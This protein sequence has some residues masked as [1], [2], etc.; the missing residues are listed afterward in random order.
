MCCAPSAPHAG[1]LL[2]NSENE[3]DLIFSVSSSLTEERWRFPAHSVILGTSSP[4][5]QTLVNSNKTIMKELAEQNRK[6]EIYVQCPPEIF[7]LVLSYIYTNELTISSVSNC[8]LLLKVAIKFE[9]DNLIYVCLTFLYDKTSPTNLIDIL[10]CLYELIN[11]GN[12]C[13]TGLQ[14]NNST[15]SSNSQS[16]SPSSSSSSNQQQE[17]SSK[18]KSSSNNLQPFGAN[19]NN[20]R[21]S[22]YPER[23]SPIPGGGRISPYFDGSKDSKVMNN[24]TTALSS[25]PSDNIVPQQPG[26]YNGNC[27]A[28]LNKLFFKCFTILDAHAELILSSDYVNKIDHSLLIDILSRDTLKINCEL[29]TFNLVKRW[30]SQACLKTRQILSS[31]NKR[32]LAG[33]A[34]YL[35]R[36]LT[37]S[38]TDFLQGPYVSDLLISE[39]KEVLYNAIRTG[40]V[41]Q[42]D[43]QMYMYDEQESEFRFNENGTINLDDFDL[44]S[45]SQNRNLQWLLTETKMNVKRKYSRPTCLVAPNRINLSNNHTLLEELSN[46]KNNNSQQYGNSSANG[47]IKK[48]SRPKKLLNGIGDFIICFIQL[49][50]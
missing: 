28:I 43:D 17:I 30:S 8:L 19:T 21:L 29:T 34:L 3:S 47:T 2:F 26:N 25:S 4:V 37:M 50:D 44:K 38:E 20:G 36:Y 35:V 13:F 6:P 31:E 18:I 14:F 24:Q 49:L 41:N 23:Y 9:L 15:N 42:G 48:K 11:S 16:N 7:H 45:H 40:Y 46:D 10:S 32:A 12:L 39:E 27:N 33:K 5:F 1:P 22:P